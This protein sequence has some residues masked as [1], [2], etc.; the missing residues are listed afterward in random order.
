[1]AS[2][3]E[4]TS[5][6]FIAS[7]DIVPKAMTALLSMSA[8][9]YFIGWRE[10]HAYYTALGAG[11]AASNVPSLALLQLSTHTLVAVATAAFF[12]LVLILDRAVSLQKISWFC[13]GCLLIAG[14]FLFASQ[15]PL[16]DQSPSSAHILASI[17][18]LFCALSAGATLSE[19]IGRTRESRQTLSSGHL[20]LVYWFILPGLF[21]APDRLGQA[22]AMRDVESSSTHLPIVQ[23]EGQASLDQWRLV[24]L[25]GDKA[26]LVSFAD[27][28]HNR[29]FKFIEVKDVKAFS[30][31]FTPT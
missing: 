27:K 24:Q 12:S 1:M 16:G 25:M 30:S 10:A 9:G 4:Q 5:V 29:R 28:A 20:W 31:T 6:S 14:V 13:A 22:R 19:L 8:L 21:W 2:Q 26:L 23:I 18:S 17:G 7:V 11:W 15:W 3:G